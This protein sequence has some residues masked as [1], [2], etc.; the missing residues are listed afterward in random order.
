MT[1]GHGDEWRD[2]AILEK[3]PGEAAKAIEKARTRISNYENGIA[4]PF[5][6]LL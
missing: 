1:H 5:G 4:T 3:G 6:I 2:E